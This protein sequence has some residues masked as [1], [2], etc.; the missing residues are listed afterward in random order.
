MTTYI[1]DVFRSDGAP[2]FWPATKWAGSTMF[3]NKA[4]SCCS[5]LQYFAVCRGNAVDK[6]PQRATHCSTLQHTATRTTHTVSK[7][8]SSRP[9]TQYFP[10]NC[11]TLQSTLQHTLQHAQQYTATHIATHI[12]TH[13]VPSSA[14]I[15]APQRQLAS[16]LNHFYVRG[17]LCHDQFIRGI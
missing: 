5:V 15:P 10:T 4:V 7:S 3:W 11:I 14:F 17:R 2:V 6:A 8:A 12:T 16:V 9:S 1:G 13:S